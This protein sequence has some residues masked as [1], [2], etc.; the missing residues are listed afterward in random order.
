MFSVEVPEK[1]FH[2]R[3]LPRNTAS[4]EAAFQKVAEEQ[5]D[6]NVVNG[7]EIVRTAFKVALKEFG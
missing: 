7:P 4:G 1:R 2:A 5:A 6:S 3:E